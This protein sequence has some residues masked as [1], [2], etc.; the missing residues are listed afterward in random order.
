M[1]KGAE[2]YFPIIQQNEIDTRSALLIKRSSN[3]EEVMDFNKCKVYYISD[4]HLPQKLE[5]VI[6]KSQK[7]DDIVR[8]LLEKIKLSDFGNK[9]LLLGGDISCDFSI[10]KLFVEKLKNCIFEL[11]QE[12]KEKNEFM[13]SCLGDNAITIKVVFVLGNHEF[14][15]F[16]RK[17]VNEVF[18]IYKD[19]LNKNGMF[20][21]NNNLLLFKENDIEEISEEEIEKMS[22]SEIFNCAK[23]AREIVFGGT[24]FSGYNEELNAD[25]GV[26][27]KAID[28]R[29]EKEESSKIERLYSKICS[30]F[31]NKKVVILTHMPPVD[32]CHNFEPHKNFVYVNGHT[33]KNNFIDN[34][35]ISIYADN[36]VG[37]YQKNFFLKYFYLDNRYDIFELYQ[38][39]IYE[40][41]R[42][43]Y[44]DF[45]RGKNISVTFN[46]NFVKLY[47]LKK[48][49]FYMFIVET[50]NESLSVLN[51]GA[52]KKLDKNDIN[53][54][55]SNM[56]A[57]IEFLQNAIVLYT[58]NQE[59]IAEHVKK[60]GGDGRIHGAI[61]D[62][63][64]YNH[65]YVDPIGGKVTPYYAKDV[66]NKVIYKDIGG[67]LVDHSPKLLANYVKQISSG[68]EKAAVIKKFSKETEIYLDT[69]I[70]KISNRL[71]KIQMLE[72]PIKVL[73]LW[74]EKGQKLLEE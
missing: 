60:I 47:M 8:K 12:F 37:Y 4:I 26:Y 34:G 49:G 5:K 17:T 22:D 48:N 9:I 74:I 67:L 68:K 36:Q 33:H 61:I 63:D 10:F 28:R 18:K 45:Y 35:T 59:N 31:N 73:V 44:Y 15:D 1:N 71:K 46:L 50:K 56:D 65:L 42:D 29:T 64:F 38:D 57:E 3:V 23:D 24:G 39:G 66:K 51:K 7:I 27:R 6:F 53:Y 2:A 55:F 21:L 58:K 43:E 16:E 52:R 11:K 20:L 13:A 72:D 62:I 14:W 69:D 40:I 54:Y 25:N 41:T 30:A 32:W 70:Y 19:L